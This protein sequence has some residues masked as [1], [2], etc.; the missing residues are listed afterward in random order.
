MLVYVVIGNR[1]WDGSYIMNIHLNE[2][3]AEEEVKILNDYNI[4]MGVK[5]RYHV[6][7]VGVVEDDWNKKV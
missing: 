1:K 2:K 3:K 5:T 4:R 6:E 7:I